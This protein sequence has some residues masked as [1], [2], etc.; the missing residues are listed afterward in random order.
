MRNKPTV[1]PN[2]WRR[3]LLALLLVSSVLIVSAPREGNSAN[4]TPAQPRK[5]AVVFAVSAES[6]EGSIT[7]GEW[8]IHYR[9]P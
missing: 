2:N 1:L 6:G 3:L 8:G 5:G 7:A 4:T 9:V